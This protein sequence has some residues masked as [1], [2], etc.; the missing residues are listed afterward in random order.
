M[1]WLLLP[2]LSLNHI[3]DLFFVKL[4]FEVYLKSRAFTFWIGSRQKDEIARVRGSLEE[5]TREFEKLSRRNDR[6]MERQNAIG[7]RTS[8]GKVLR[9]LRI[10]DFA[11]DRTY[12]GRQVE[13]CQ[14]NTT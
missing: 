5:S 12:S 11:T 14:K 7:N 4:V 9:W 6:K 8:Q 3:L 10:L 1:Y 2:R 13:T